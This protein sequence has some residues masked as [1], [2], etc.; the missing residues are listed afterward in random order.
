MND[1][2]PNPYAAGASDPGGQ[3]QQGSQNQTIASASRTG[4]AITAALAMGLIAFTGI[5]LFLRFSDSDSDQGWVPTDESEMIFLAIGLLAFVSSFAVSLVLPKLMRRAQ[6]ERFRSE[7]EVLPQPL[8]DDAV[9]PPSARFFLG[10]EM[11]Q[12]LVGQALCEGPAVMNLV[13]F[14]IKGNLLHL[15]PVGLGLLGIL[16]RVPTTQKLRARLQEAS[17]TARDALVR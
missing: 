10:G 1:P 3:P 17:Q 6:Q 5:A 9:L 12:I 2:V 15:I 7:Q 14:L 8:L 4:S 13:F 16:A 11:T